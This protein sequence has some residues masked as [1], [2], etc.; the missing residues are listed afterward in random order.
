[1]KNCLMI[2]F[3]ASV[4]CFADISTINVVS[5]N[6]ID[7]ES[8]ATVTEMYEHFKR[9]SGESFETEDTVTL[10]DGDSCQYAIT[11][12]GADTF[13]HMIFDVYTST[14]AVVTFYR[15]VPPDSLDGTPDTIQAYN[16]NFNSTDSVSTALIQ[17]G[18]MIVKDYG[19]KLFVEHFGTA[20]LPSG[21]GRAGGKARSEGEYVLKPNTTYLIDI[22][23]LADGNKVNVGSHFYIVV[24]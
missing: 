22:R 1:M 9:H 19:T 13:V 24:E 7:T 11:T 23:S 5:G 18:K 3:W 4:F 8:G 17:K 6:P 10:D 20:G 21:S 12:C 14:S 2:V 15:N 16:V